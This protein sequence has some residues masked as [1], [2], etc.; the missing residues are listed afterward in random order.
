MAR[1]GREW[2]ALDSHDSHAVRR[3]VDYWLYDVCGYE[4]PS[5]QPAD[6]SGAE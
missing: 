2:L 5:A 6:A 3:Y 1:P 4:R